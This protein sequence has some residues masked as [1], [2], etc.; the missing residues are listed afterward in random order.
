[1]NVTIELEK[2]VSIGGVEHKTAVLR[3]PTAFDVIEAMKESEVLVTVPVDDG[4]GK[5]MD[6]Q[7]VTS[8]T[9]VG[10][11]LMLRQI[12]SIA[13]FKEPIDESILKLLSATD[14][15]LLQ[16]A[17]ENLDNVSRTVTQRGRPDGEG[18]NNEDNDKP[19]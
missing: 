8:P 1:M 3:P 18:A 17:A 12:V 13:E 4:D 19:S 9:R 15:N 16:S 6:A 2:G 10:L 14:L 5:R 11:N 7:L